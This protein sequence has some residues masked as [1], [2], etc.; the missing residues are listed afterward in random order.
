MNENLRMSLIILL[1]FLIGCNVGIMVNQH[2]TNRAME[3]VSTS[4][5]TMTAQGNIVSKCL[6]TLT[7]IQQVVK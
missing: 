5:E 2:T 4:V 6:D 1:A 7:Q 3:L